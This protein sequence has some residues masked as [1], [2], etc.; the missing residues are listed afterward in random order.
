MLIF[1]AVNQKSQDL[2]DQVIKKLSYAKVLG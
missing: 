1:S 2:T